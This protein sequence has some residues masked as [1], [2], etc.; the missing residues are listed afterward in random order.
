MK[1][2]QWLLTFKNMTWEE[3]LGLEDF[4]QD[5]LADEYAE[6]NWDPDK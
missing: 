1:F 5:L 6:G 3:Y 2:D 4:E